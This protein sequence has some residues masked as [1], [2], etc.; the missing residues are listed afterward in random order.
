MR[1]I[2]QIRRCILLH[3]GYT[4]GVT[5]FLYT[6][7]PMNSLMIITHSKR[8][9]GVTRTSK[10]RNKLR[11]LNSQRP[12]VMKNDPSSASSKRIRKTTNPGMYSK[13][14]NRTCKVVKYRTDKTWAAASSRKA[15]VPADLVASGG[16]EVWCCNRGL[17]ATLRAVLKSLNS[18]RT[19]I[20]QPAACNF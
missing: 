9:N 12:A 3:L 1:P 16:L 13:I 11:T 5:L 2:H 18:P 20:S 17:L 7:S 19:D 15:S 6:S 10:Y 14:E 8:A 4:P